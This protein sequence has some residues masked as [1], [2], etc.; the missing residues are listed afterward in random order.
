MFVARRGRPCPPLKMIEKRRRYE[1]CARRIKMLVAAGRLLVGIEAL[2]RPQHELIRGTWYATQSRSR[3]SS[4]SSVQP[5]HAA[6]DERPI[7][8]T[9]PKK[10]SS[11]PA[12]S[13]D[14][15][16]YHPLRR[17][18]NPAIAGFIFFDDDDSHVRERVRDVL[19]EVG[20]PWGLRDLPGIPRR[21][22]SRPRSI[23]SQLF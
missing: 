1:T 8:P 18:L 2:R 17:Q 13:H 16:H 3:S 11:R 12:A 21:V 6:T 22:S 4:M 23:G 7:S 19:E 20:S 5:V 15:T 10:S 9:R 14:K